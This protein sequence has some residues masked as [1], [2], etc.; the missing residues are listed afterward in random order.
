[1]SFAQE[2]CKVY[3]KFGGKPRYAVALTS[4]HLKVLLTLSLFT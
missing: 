3:W 2:V 4:Y 1:M